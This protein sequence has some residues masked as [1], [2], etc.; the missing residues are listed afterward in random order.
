MR[1]KY[2]G[3]WGT[4]Q[5]VNNAFKYPVRFI[6]E[7]LA[8]GDVASNTSKVSTVPLDDHGMLQ[9]HTGRGIYM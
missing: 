9:M 4:P 5:G 1:S 2:V 3:M 8:G 6:L 7:D